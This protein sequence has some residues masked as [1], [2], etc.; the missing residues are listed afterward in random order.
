M[1]RAAHPHPEVI[2]VN[3]TTTAPALAVTLALALAACG[4]TTASPTPTPT[5]SPSPTP[6]VTP[7][8]TE[9]ETAATDAPTDGGS[10]ITGSLLDVLPDE[11]GGFPRQEIP[12]LEAIIEPMLAQSG[13]DAEDADF[14]FASWG[15]GTDALIVTAMRIPGLDQA[16]LELLARLMSSSQAGE[17]DFEAE[18]V[19][20][21]GKQV[22]RMS[23]PDVPAAAYVY[24]AGD[25]FFSVIGES[26]DLAEELLSQLP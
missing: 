14:A 25:A 26:T 8:P 5:A 16:Q 4:G 10:T 22:L 2:P 6:E 9:S 19:T 23:G 12:G 11:V 3:R 21:G 17:T 20:V 24:F 1:L 13:V 18:T 7:S 15:D